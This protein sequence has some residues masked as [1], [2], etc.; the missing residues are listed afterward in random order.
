MKFELRP[1]NRNLTDEEI[2]AEINRIDLVVG[3]KFLTMVDFNKHSTIHSDT[4]KRRFGGWEK[5]LEK[6]GI[7]EKYAGLKIIS[8]K[9]KGQ[10]TKL[11][12][13]EQI[14]NELKRIAKELGKNSITRED[15][16]RRSKIIAGSAVAY[17]FGSWLNGLEKAGL[18]KS[19]NY[20]IKFSENQLFENI[21]NVWTH[22]GRQPLYAEMAKSPSVISPGTYESRFG[23]WRKALEAFVLKMNQDD[24]STVEIIENES[25]PEE[26]DT[27]DTNEVIK[28]NKTQVGEGRGINLSLRYKVLGRDN[29]KCV[30]CG[31][32]PA[33]NLGVELHID[34]KLPFSMGGKTILENL[35]TKCKECNL[36]K[37]NRHTE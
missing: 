31:R 25:V 34:H 14:L 4:I 28:E 7:I 23:S 27:I 2:I 10:E 18:N 35:E 21:F 3:K 5:A 33:T 32:T 36:G 11:L 16:N 37:G 9:V 6:A 17:R 22:Y 8:D 12:T 24:S 20:R 26:Q 30:R 15:V 19:I 1:D 29:F 13:D